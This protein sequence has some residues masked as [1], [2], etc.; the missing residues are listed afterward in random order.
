MSI[1]VPHLSLV[2]LVIINNLLFEVISF[3]F[4]FDALQFLLDQFG[5][6]IEKRS[7][8]NGEIF[9]LFYQF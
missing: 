1:S 5:F 4:V 3:V 2:L 6:G 9:V 8:L 7:I